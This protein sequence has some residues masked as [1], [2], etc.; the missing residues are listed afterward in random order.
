MRELSRTEW[1]AL[2]DE[3]CGRP[4][5]VD[6][7]S[8]IRSGESPVVDI[9]FGD[10]LGPVFLSSVSVYA[11]SDATDVR[12]GQIQLLVGRERVA[13]VQSHPPY[14]VKRWTLLFEGVLQK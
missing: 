13:L 11:E 7:K 1:Q 10:S 9:E 6:V 4:I 3:H 8:T 12:V 14:P 5:D 2:R